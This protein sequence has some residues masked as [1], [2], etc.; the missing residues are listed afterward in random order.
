M[1]NRFRSLFILALCCAPV[2]AQT[3]ATKQS[4]KQTQP[5]G[6]TLDGVVSMVED[7]LSDDLIIARIRK[8]GKPFDLSTDDMIR[9]HPSRGP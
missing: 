6:L 8:E 1:S 9:P 7:G 5:T 2:F 4:S 3:G